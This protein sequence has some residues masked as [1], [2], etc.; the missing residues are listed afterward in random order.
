V[1]G[2]D[3]ENF[4]GA[5]GALPQSVAQGNQGEFAVNC[6]IQPTRIDFNMMP[7]ASDDPVKLDVI[8]D[9]ASVRREFERIVGLVR[10]GLAVG[11]AVNRVATFFHFLSVGKN[12]AEANAT[13][14]G[15]IPSSYRVK[16]SDEEEFSLQLNRPRAS[17]VEN[18]RINR[19]TKWSVIRYQMIRVAV[20]A[21]VVAPGATQAAQVTNMAE[22][23]AA[24]VTFDINN[25]SVAGAALTADQQVK[26]LNEGLADTIQLMLECGLRAKG[27]ENA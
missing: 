9:A 24:N 1:W 16:L 22:A 2:R 15:V 6:A 13:L 26:L 20:P 10:D 18:L 4:Q 12:I 19:I 17:A 8:E 5:S 27:F 3:P 7:L 23:I 14:A 21:R 25:T 11:I